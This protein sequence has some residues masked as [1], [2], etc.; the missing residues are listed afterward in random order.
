MNKLILI[1]SFILVSNVAHA[2]TF[3]GC[4]KSNHGNWECTYHLHVPS[5]DP[6]HNTY[7]DETFGAMDTE[8]TE[9]SARKITDRTANDAEH[10]DQKSI[11]AWVGKVNEKQKLLRLSDKE[12]AITESKKTSF[13][14]PDNKIN[15]TPE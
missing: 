12:T 6:P 14:N 10:P 4:K 11:D 3:K 15:G 7:I 5:V 8:L 13:V 1:L 2:A 9:A